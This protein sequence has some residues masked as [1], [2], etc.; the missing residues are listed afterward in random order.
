MGA[1]ISKPRAPK[2]NENPDMGLR[3]AWV[4]FTSKTDLPWLRF[5][6][7]GFRHCYALLND[8]KVW[9]SIDPMSNYTDISVHHHL[10]DD[11]DLPRWLERR[12]AIVVPAST[13]RKQTEAPWGIIS[14]VESVKRIFGIHKR[15]IITPYQLYRY[16]AT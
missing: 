1:L 12:G 11:F 9:I 15:G 6:K 3:S 7:P 2:V 4:V 14:C 16:L 13:S 8:G 10:P 5:L